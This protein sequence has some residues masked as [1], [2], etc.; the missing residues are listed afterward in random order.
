MRGMPVHAM[1]RFVLRTTDA[2][3]ARGFYAALLGHER[4]PI[5]ALH[6]Q[7]LARG[8]RP[9]WLGQIEVEDVERTAGAFVELGAE[10]LGPIGT[11]PTGR[12]FAVLRD[13]GGAIVGLTSPDVNEEPRAVCWHQLASLDVARATAAYTTLFGWQLTQQITHPEHGV[14]QHFAWTHGGQDVGTIHDIVGREG[15]HPHWLFHLR[16]DSLDRAIDLVRS[17]HGLV[18]G[19]FTL[20]SGERIAV[21]DDPQGAAFA[22][23]GSSEPPKGE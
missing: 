10:M 2:H 17:H 21:C 13:P 18:L 5:V 15:R 6:E 9:H 19:P 12:R 16:V 4:M 20:T 14:L 8:A 23:R 7:A 22:I 3:A 11:F 1:T